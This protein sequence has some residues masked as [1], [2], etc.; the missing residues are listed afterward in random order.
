MGFRSWTLIDRSR[1]RNNHAPN[2]DFLIPLRRYSLAHSSSQ[3]RSRGLD[4][5][6]LD[7]CALFFVLDD[8]FAFLAMTDSSLLPWHFYYVWQAI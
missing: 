7:D 1:C 6:G 8:I 4:R 2:A 5:L 3:S